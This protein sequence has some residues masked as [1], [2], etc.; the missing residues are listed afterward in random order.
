MQ[1]H[2]KSVVRSPFQPRPSSQNPPSRLLSS[3]LAPGTT[4]RIAY[5]CRV[6]HVDVAQRR[7]AV[8]G[9]GGE[10]LRG[11]DLL[12]GSDGVRSRVRAAMGSQLPPGRF[13]SELRVMPGR[14][15][16]RRG[17]SRGKT[18]GKHGK[19]ITKHGN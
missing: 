11:Y 3:P 13:D 4:V 8:V 14:R 18:M 6:G 15:T 17:T 2:A 1:N 7:I 10:A 9:Q 12:V 5:E 16:G 19:T